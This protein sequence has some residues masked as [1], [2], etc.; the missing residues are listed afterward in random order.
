[1]S[2]FALFLNLNDE[3]VVCL[4]QEAAGSLD[5][6]Q[7]EAILDFSSVRRIDAGTLR[8]LDD[9]ARVAHE[10]AV[11]IVLRGVNVEVYKVLKLV[12]LM[13]RFFVTT[14]MAAKG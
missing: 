13:Q 7:G 5:G 2:E 12:K 1:M 3:C 9:F 10:K 8:A 6:A 14:D 4:L 11:R